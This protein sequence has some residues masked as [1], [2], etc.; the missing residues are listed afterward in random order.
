MNMRTQDQTDIAI[1]LGKFTGAGGYNCGLTMSTDT[2]LQFFF[3]TLSNPQD[4]GEL[5]N[6]DTAS[7]SQVMYQLDRVPGASVTR[8]LGGVNVVHPVYR[9]NRFIT[10]KVTGQSQAVVTFFRI[11]FARKNN[12]VFAPLATCPVDLSKVRFE[13][14]MART[15][16]QDIT[17][18]QASRSQLNFSRYGATVDLVN[19]D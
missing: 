2:T 8:Q 12:A 13:V 11:A 9:L 10:G 16:I 3:Q 7:V 5:G 19:W 6:P 4:A 15:G 1:A 18:D 17:S 14:Q